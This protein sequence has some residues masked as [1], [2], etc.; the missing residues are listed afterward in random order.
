MHRHYFDDGCGPSHG[1]PFGGG[2]RAGCGRHGAASATSRADF[3]VAEG[4]ADALFAPAGAWA[5]GDLQLVL[6]ALLAERASHGYE[7]MKALEERSGG[8]Y[9]PSPGMIYPAL[10]WLEEVGYASVAA[11]GAKKLYSIT[12]AGREHLRQNQEAADA[13]LSQLEH[14]GR[15]LGRVREV[16]AGFED[17]ETAA[18]LRGGVGASRTQAGAARRARRLPAGADA[19]RADPRRRRQDPPS[20]LQRTP[21]LRAPRCVRDA[22]PLRS[23]DAAL[24][25]HRRNSQGASDRARSARLLA[26]RA[27]TPAP[28]RAVPR[29]AAAA[30][31]R[32]GP[33]RRPASLMKHCPVGHRLAH[34]TKD[35]K[36]AR[37][38]NKV[39]LIGNLGADPETRAM[40]S[41]TTVANLRIATSE[42]WRDKQSGEQQE[43]TEWHRV[44]LFGRLA[45][46]AGEYLRKGSQVYIEGS[47]RTRKWQDKQGNDRYSTEIVGNDLQMLG[48]RGGGG[49]S[50][51]SRGAAGVAAGGAGGG[52]PALAEESAGG[53]ASRSEE[54][55]DD[56]PF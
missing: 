47:L 56:I 30:N 36:M 18:Q 17:E 20:G 53:G 5:S 48:G 46:V 24:P 11:D 50:E 37:G 35:I 34:S 32:A 23:N 29:A 44:A 55:D 45:E 10:T 1:R 22:R 7:L 13:M 51:A 49:G 2:Y 38:V 31:L 15:K 40:P 52:A 26:A 9:S 25:R 54:F 6:L 19:H 4:R 12:E 8:F 28:K 3:S 16:F 43:R 42:S 21:L 39:I 41:G 14:I 33:A 27:D